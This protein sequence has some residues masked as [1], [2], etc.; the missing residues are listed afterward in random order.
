MSNKRF[1]LCNVEVTKYRRQAQPVRGAITAL[2]V[3]IEEF[4]DRVNSS[5]KY[6]QSQRAFGELSEI[7][8][9]LKFMYLSNIITATEYRKIYCNLTGTEYEEEL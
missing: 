4:Q 2:D 7:V 9:E 1:F 5:E 8:G 3:K 6:C